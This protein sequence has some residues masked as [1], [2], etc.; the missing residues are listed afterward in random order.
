MIP[1]SASFESEVVASAPKDKAKQAVGGVQLVRL[2]FP[3]TIDT[4]AVCKHITECVVAIYAKRA[5]KD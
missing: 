2:S 3:P 1:Y 5:R 4:K